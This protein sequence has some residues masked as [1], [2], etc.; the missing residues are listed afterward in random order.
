[1]I[2]GAPSLETADVLNELAQLRRKSA[3]GCLADFF[4]KAP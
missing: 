1:M 2:M 4:E 3:M